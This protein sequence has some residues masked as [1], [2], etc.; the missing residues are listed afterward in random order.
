[1]NGDYGDII[2]RLKNVFDKIKS[3]IGD[4]H[5]DMKREV[6]ISALIHNDQFGFELNTEFVKFLS[7]YG[8]S[9]GFSSVV[10]FG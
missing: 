5:Q 9:L 1:M 6:Y 10:L 2:S 8:Y 4:N 7:E 3:I